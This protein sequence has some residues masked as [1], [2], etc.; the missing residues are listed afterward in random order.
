MTI[1]KKSR[2]FISIALAAASLVVL[3]MSLQ[4][5][6]G[7][8][9]STANA[10]IPNLAALKKVPAP[11]DKAPSGIEDSA[12]DIGEGGLDVKSIRKLG[13]G[14]N[15]TYW[16]GRDSAGNICLVFLLPSGTSGHACAAPEDF[17]T[18]GTGVAL[19]NMETGEYIEAH[20]LPDGALP[21]EGKLYRQDAPGVVV[22]DPSLRSSRGEKI[23]IPTRKGEPIQFTVQ[24]EVPRDQ[25]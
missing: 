24:G 13:Q 21:Q 7:S 5:F 2:L 14:E 17:N 23:E 1:S 19:E 4:A 11:S 18:D 8:T 20:L 15:A 12:A 16:A 3:A 22:I 25:L 6:A 9:S 10:N